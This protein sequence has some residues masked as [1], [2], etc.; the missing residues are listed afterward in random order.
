M[1]DE[2]VYYEDSLSGLTILIT[3]LGTDDS[4]TSR[5]VTSYWAYVTSGSGLITSRPE[6]QVGTG[7]G[8]PLDIPLGG[9]GAV[10]QRWKWCC[11]C[12]VVVVDVV[13]FI[14]LNIF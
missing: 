11:C 10:L 9:G 7:N 12:P 1:W 8:I 2:S 6:I 5:V 3:Q 14:D 13:T 4:E